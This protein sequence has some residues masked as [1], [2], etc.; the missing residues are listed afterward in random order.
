M[1]YLRFECRILVSPTR[2]IG[3]LETNIWPLSTNEAN[4]PDLSFVL[5]YLAFKRRVYQLKYSVALP[6]LQRRPVPPPSQ[7][8][9]NSKD[10]YTV[11]YNREREVYGD[12]QIYDVNT[13]IH[14][15]TPL[16]FVTHTSM[17]LII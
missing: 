6:K 15:H 9:K 10:Q 2:H 12:S 14:T 13:Q 8:V 3:R 16:S 11:N 5:L 17:L 4:H 7:S 1:G